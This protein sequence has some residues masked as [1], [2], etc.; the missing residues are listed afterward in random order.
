MAFKRIALA[1]TLLLS[2]PATATAIDPG[3]TYRRPNGEVAMV[4]VSGGKLY[5]KIIEGRAR[6][7]EMCNGMGKTSEESWAG[8][9]MK[10]P[11]MPGF[12]TFNGTVDV[13]PTGLAVKGCAIRQ[14][15][16]DREEWIRSN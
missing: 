14:S 1:A 13:T 10:H 7:F 6:G 12:M 5:C 16:C 3:S 2:G 11:Q 15:F 4:T 8:P 9:R